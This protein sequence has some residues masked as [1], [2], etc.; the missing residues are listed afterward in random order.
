MNLRYYSSAY[1][2]ATDYSVMEIA[3][4]MFI[5]LGGLCW[6]NLVAL[7]IGAITSK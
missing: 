4:G 2:K 6:I 7:F 3:L 5:G 1:K